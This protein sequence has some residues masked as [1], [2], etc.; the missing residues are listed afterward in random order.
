MNVGHHRGAIWSLQFFPIKNHDRLLD[1]GCGG[2]RNISIMAKKTQNTVFGLDYSIASINKAK[3]YNKK[4]IANGSVKIALGD[5]SQLPFS[6]DTFDGVTAFETVYF[7]PDL[8][9]NFAEVAK[10]LKTGGHFM[11]ANEAY[12]EKDTRL[13]KKYIDLQIYS[14]TEIADTMEQTGFSSIETHIH[15]NGKWF[16]VVGTK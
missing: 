14:P 11:V 1:I 15:A 12:A 10:V 7:W 2:G 16:V 3:K 6:S 13:W 4:A 8:T 9:Q 5:V